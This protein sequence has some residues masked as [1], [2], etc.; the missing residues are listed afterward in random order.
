MSVTS[1]GG[2]PGA[3][4]YLALIREWPLLPIRSKADLDRAIAM[5]DALSDRESLSPEEHDYLLVLAGL[6]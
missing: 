5:L 6:V 3:E 4:G 2:R 1:R